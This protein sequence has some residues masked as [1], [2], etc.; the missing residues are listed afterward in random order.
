VNRFYS[1]QQGRFTQ[2]DPIEMDA[3]SLD[4]PQ[5]LN[6]YSYCGNDPMNHIDP[7]GL[8]FGWLKKA[9]GAIKKFFSN[10]IV[11]IAVIVALTVITLGAASGA[12][13]LFVTIPI[14][15]TAAVAVGGLNALGWTAAVLAGLS[16][17]SLPGVGGLGGYGGFKTPGTFPGGTGIGAVSDFQRVRKQPPPKPKIS[18]L[19]AATA[20]KYLGSKNWLTKSK[21]GKA[22]AGTYKC[23]LFVHEVLKEAGA[24]APT[25]GKGKWPL[26]AG[27]W[28]NPKL[29]IAGW[30]VLAP[31][32]KWLPGDVLARA[33]AS[34]GATGHVAIVSGEGK[35]TGTIGDGTIREGDFGSRWYQSDNPWFFQEKVVVRRCT[36]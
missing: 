7:E 33:E 19:I 16:G 24:P 10:T 23:S 27:S 29:K 30:R 1:A 2:V 5:T 6:L 35:V 20:K 4:D 32:E 25:T 26:Q 9:F 8:F 14:E 17:I 3:A 28:A 11:K 22:G 18:D 34:E 31:G 36:K 13:S 15:G 21:R 12:W